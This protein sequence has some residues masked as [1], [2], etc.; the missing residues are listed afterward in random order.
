MTVADHLLVIYLLL[1][2]LLCV[3][4]A[5][6]DI[7]S[8]TKQTLGSCTVLVVM[9]RA[10]LATTL[11]LRSALVCQLKCRYRL[12]ILVSRCCQ[13]VYTT[14]HVLLVCCSSSAF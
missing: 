1:F 13:L 11:A 4:F 6:F 14:Q 5:L 12:K 8:V 2:V 10:S 3:W 9:T 7:I